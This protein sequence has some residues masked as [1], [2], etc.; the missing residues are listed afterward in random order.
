MRNGSPLARQSDG[1]PD[2]KTYVLSEQPRLPG[3][4]PQR[5]V[6]V[7]NIDAE[8]RMHEAL[9]RSERRLAARKPALELVVSGL[10]SVRCPVAEERRSRVGC[11]ARVALY[12][13]DPD[14]VA[15]RRGSGHVLALYEC[16]HG[17]ESRPTNRTYGR[18]G[19]LEAKGYLKK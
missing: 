17:F 7:D 5:V 3:T 12:I 2:A 9:R 16:R 8:K 6:V 10:P 11:D 1:D 4:S 18:V 15:F 13:V 19:H 14:A